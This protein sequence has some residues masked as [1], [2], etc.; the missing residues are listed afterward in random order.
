MNSTRRPATS[1]ARSWLDRR[2]GV[3]TSR[4]SVL[5]ISFLVAL[6]ALGVFLD[7]AE[8]VRGNEAIVWDE[9]AGRFLHGYS[10]P[11]LDALMHGIS[12]LGSTPVIAS[13]LAVAVGALLVRGKRRQAVFL[14]VAQAGG[15]A[16]FLTMSNY[17]ERP[18]P[19]LPWSPRTVGYAFPSGHSLNSFVLYLG[20]ATVAWVLWG[21]RVGL[22]AY[23]AAALVVLLVGVS[24][25]YGG[26]HYFSDVV[27]GFSAGLFW[28]IAAT[29][30]V[31]P[32]RGGRT[33]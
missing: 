23:A 14:L 25:I 28:L 5:A 2:L 22:A 10:T 4:F 24:R 11:L 27:G 32:G 30:A 12:F 9:G 8:D 16:I 33:A 31:G 29:V 6:G 17:F 1:R 20:L 19:R 18:R 3:P 13:I 7:Y 21:R 26:Y 15:S